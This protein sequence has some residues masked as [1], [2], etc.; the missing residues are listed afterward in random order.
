MVLPAPE[1]PTSATVS[2][3]RT[4]RSTPSSA[5]GLGPRRIVEGHALEA[6]SRPGPARGSGSGSAGSRTGSVGA[7]ELD[8]PLGR[9]GSALQFAPDLG[10]RSPP[11]P[12]PSPRRSRTA[13]ARPGSSPPPARRARRSTARPTTPAKTRKITITVI[14]ARVRDPRAAPS[15][16]RFSV[17]AANRARLAPSWVKACTV[18]AA[19]QRLGRHCA[20]ALAIQSWFSRA[21]RA[22]APAQHKD[23]HHHQRHHQQHQ[24]GQLGRGEEQ[25]RDAPRQHQN[26]A[27]RDRDRRADHRQ[28]Q[29]GVGGDP[30]TAPRRS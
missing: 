7:Q 30:A 2:P 17:S 24:P 28:D 6:R 27:Q 15:R 11:R 9:A 4:C 16:R 12:R 3:A 13:P 20:E 10:Q 8:Q 22:Q 5:D 23:R 25:Q 19:Q 21:E 1:G 18:C 29:R 14:T 26:V